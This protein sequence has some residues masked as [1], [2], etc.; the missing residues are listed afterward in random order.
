MRNRLRQK[1]ALILLFVLA[2]SSVGP[3]A[4][5]AECS[6]APGANPVTVSLNDPSERTFLNQPFLKDGSSYLPLREMGTLLNVKT[7]WI[8]EGRRIVMSHPEVTVELAL[9]S[10]AA[11]ING[12]TVKMRSAPLNKN[13]VVYVPVRFVTQAFGG[14]VDW[15]EKQ[16]HVTLT[17]EERYLF[18]DYAGT[19]HWLARKDGLLYVAPEAEPAW[20]IADTSAEILGRGQ[21]QIESLSE[22]NVV[23]KIHDDYGEPQVHHVI[24]K[25][26]IS[27]GKL[28][29]ESESYSYAHPNRSVDW[30]GEG[31]A[32]L[33]NGTTLY[34]VNQEGAILASYDLQTLTGYE[35]EN[36]LVEWYDADYMVVR[37]ERT[38]W[39]TLVNRKTKEAVR[40]AEAL[41]TKE[42]W[43]VY[44]SLD[45]LSTEF[46]NWDGLNV[47]TRDGDTLKLGHYYFIGGINSSFDYKLN[48]IQ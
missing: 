45:Q 48:P 36:F 32:L 2:V 34:E 39:L 11:K 5:M 6:A 24:Y 16:R 14:K 28:I 7:T 10:E 9:G 46:V 26:I 8:P 15:N 22:Q 1:L 37:P 19:G 18:V 31:R 23:M 20:L 35:D 40:L 21:M 47:I 30:S 4:I 44:Q 27:S 25:M 41:L 29:L 12:E 17:R 3:H 43:D 38:G 13:G 42:Q 33:M